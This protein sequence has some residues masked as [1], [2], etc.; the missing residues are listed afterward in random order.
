MSVVKF[1]F[2]ATGSI[3]TYFQY[4]SLIYFYITLLLI[5]TAISLFFIKGKSISNERKIM[6]STWDSP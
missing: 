4:P 6:F 1:A 2:Y 5:Y 3:L